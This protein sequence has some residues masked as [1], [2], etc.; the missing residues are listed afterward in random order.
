MRTTIT[1]DD[2][3]ADALKALAHERRQPFKAVMNDAIRSG[4]KRDRPASEPFRTEGRPMRLQPGLNLHKAS[5]LADALEDEQT[6][7]RLRS[8]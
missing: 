4:L 6:V 1:L 3:L 2:D 8:R 5:M 7:A